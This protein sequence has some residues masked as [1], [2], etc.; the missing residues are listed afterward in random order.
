MK[1]IKWTRKT[2]MGVPTYH[3]SVD[4]WKFTIDKP[5]STHWILRAW[6]TGE[7]AFSVYRE[8]PTLVLAKAAAATL[9]RGL[10]PDKPCGCSSNYECSLCEMK[11]GQS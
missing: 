3:G 9:A 10:N 2:F 6:K 5:C 1:V 4:G 11:G 8:R 7:T